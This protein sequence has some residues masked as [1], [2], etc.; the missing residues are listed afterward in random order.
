[1]IPIKIIRFDESNPNKE[2]IK[3]QYGQYGDKDYS[4]SIIKNQLFINLYEGCDISITLPSVHNGFILTS[5]NRIIPIKDS[6]LT[7]KLAT[8][9]SAFGVLILNKWN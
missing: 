7:A 4:L 9:E 3:G 5:K 1:M 8:D 6:Q 2:A